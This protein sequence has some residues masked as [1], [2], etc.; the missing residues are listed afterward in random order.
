MKN[1]TSSLSCSTNLRV[2]AL[3]A[4]VLCEMSDLIIDHMRQSLDED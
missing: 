1:L 4:K 2:L 3:I